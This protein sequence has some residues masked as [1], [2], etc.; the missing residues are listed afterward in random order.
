MHIILNRS[1]KGGEIETLGTITVPRALFGCCS[2]ERP[3]KGNKPRISCYPE[4]TY[5]WRKRA[6]T[7]KIPYEHIILL[8][9]PGRS[10]ICIHI[11]N[12]VDELEGCTAVGD[13]FIDLDYNG[14]LDVTNS[15]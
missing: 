14:I 6:A 9:I 4:G 13:G 12:K 8:D 5:E 10:G 3:D 7:E 2:L 15:R 11:A 1:K